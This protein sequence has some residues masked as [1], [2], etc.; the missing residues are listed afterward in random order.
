MVALKRFFHAD[1]GISI[2]STGERDVGPESPLACNQFQPLAY[3]TPQPM[4]ARSDFQQIEKQ[5]E[6]LHEQFQT[7]PMSPTRLPTASSRSSTRPTERTPR[8]VDLLDALFSSHR[9]Q[10]QPAK[11]MSPITPY[12]EDI[13]ERN[14]T[15]FLQKPPRKKNLYS[16]L[17]S[18]LHQEDASDR[19][20]TKGRHHTSPLSRSKSSQ[21]QSRNLQTSHSSHLVTETNS[22][23]R[24]RT[25][26][27]QTTNQDTQSNHPNVLVSEKRANAR[28]TGVG[29]PPLRPQKSAPNL[30]APD[31]ASIQNP[32]PSSG[33]GLLGVPAPYKRG[34]T[35]SIMP[36]PDSPTLPIEARRGA[37]MKQ[38]K[39]TREASSKSDPNPEAQARSRNRAP[40]FSTRP[41]VKKNVR[42]L[43][44]DT[45]LA[46][47]KRSVTKIMHRS[48]QPPTP[49]SLEAKQN[50][51]IAEIMNSPLLAATPTPI[52]ALPSA[53]Q[54]VAEIMDMFKQAYTSTHAITPHPTF[55]TLQDAIV[56]EINSH[57]AFRR[58]PVPE[59]GPP[60]TPSPSQD[61]FNR[62]FS[63]GGSSQ[64]SM[65]R[66]YS[67]KDSQLSK[68]IQ[69]SSFKK[70]RRGS[71][72]HQ[73]I[74]TSVPSL[75]SGRTSESSSRRRH[76]DA[77]P[78]SPGFFDTLD[79]KRQGISAKQSE[80]QITYMDLLHRTQKPPTGTRSRKAS[81]A[82]RNLGQAQQPI[83]SMSNGMSETLHKTPSVFYMRA[84]TS[85]S[86]YGNRPRLPV[87]DSDD[88]EVIQL[89]SI[90]S[91]QL[92]I[93]GVDENNVIFVAENTTPR[94]AYKL[95]NWPRNSG[96]S[97]SL[98]GSATAGSETSSSTRC[99][100]L[101]RNAR[102]V[103]TY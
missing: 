13:A 43:S 44:I 50:P 14:M 58:V 25:R 39:P 55:E 71:E 93:H 77:P 1:K 2:C 47:Q 19:N 51:S 53:N 84:Q 94:T 64:S 70:H 40:S 54:K 99:I 69:K 65:D 15:R 42:D 78:P 41:G 61:S 36:F 79:P 31:T 95:M 33:A 87:D 5:F 90:E 27:G 17:L 96:R 30:S 9:Y 60:F 98:K 35:W 8:H 12:N 103:E 81:G 26:E 7:R 92:Q 10:M 52:S 6:V 91:P 74:S 102:S 18:V 88:E 45:E 57:E 101:V 72:L 29:R 85:P 32:H 86:L 4:E 63:S 66:A 67:L 37:S 28:D 75:M 23:R 89:P 68:L 21:T 46:S 62:S 83:G 82:S 24:S 34:S 3:K 16:R 76:T 56:R 80:E 49:S 73:S 11:N 97:V 59:P 22:R 20:L 48:I 100:P 38:S